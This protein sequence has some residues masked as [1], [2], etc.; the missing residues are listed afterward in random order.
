MIQ[1]PY[2]PSQTAAK[3]PQTAQFG[4]HGKARV[5]TQNLCSRCNTAEVVSG[6]VIRPEK[7]SDRRCTRRF[8]QRRSVTSKTNGSLLPVEAQSRSGVAQN[9][10]SA[11]RGIALELHEVV[12]ASP[13]LCLNSKCAISSEVMSSSV[14]RHSATG[15]LDDPLV[16]PDHRSR[17]S[18]SYGTAAL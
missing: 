9:C 7:S 8:V 6:V 12:A 1:D 14:H 2:K 4:Q 11:R 15:L 10:S 16:L 18:T 17:H 3:A 13:M 5:A